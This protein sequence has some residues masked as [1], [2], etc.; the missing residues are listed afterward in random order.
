MKL[1]IILIIAGILLHFYFKLFK[2]PK[3]NN[4]VLTSGGVKT[5]KSSLT[6]YF[7]WKKYKAALRWYKI[8][9]FVIGIFSKKKADE[10]EKPLLYSNIPLKCEYVPLTKEIILRQQRPRY[11]SVVFVDEASLLADSMAWT[12]D[13]VN[14][15]IRLFFKLIAHETHGGCAVIDSQQPTDLHFGIKRNISSYFYIHRIRKLPFFIVLYVR[16]MLYSDEA[17]VQ[18]VFND[19]IEFGMRRII[20]S[21]RIWKMFDCFAF[22]GLTDA[23]PVADQVVDGRKLKD[24]KVRGEYL[25]FRVPRKSKEEKKN[26]KG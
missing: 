18:N 12:D 15:N 26:V 11:K 5:G 21:K 7:A 13:N 24:L 14:E 25:T 9:K 10:I 1:L 20:M 19:D 23:L 2:I 16:E 6:V 4:L 17:G 3:L 22:S 8:S